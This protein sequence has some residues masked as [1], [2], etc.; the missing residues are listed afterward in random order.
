MTQAT[1]TADDSSRVTLGSR[2]GFILLVGLVGGVLGALVWRGA[3]YFLQLQSVHFI[4][5]AWI[6]YI[7]VLFAG[8]VVR[9]PGAIAISGALTAVVASIV[10]SVASLLL[11]GVG[12]N[13][14]P[15]HLLASIG[16]FLVQLV[17][18]VVVGELIGVALWSRPAVAGR[19]WGISVAVVVA[20]LATSA[21]AALREILSDPVPVLLQSVV[22]PVLAVLGAVLAAAPV[23]D[24]LRQ[25]DVL[26]SART[27]VGVTGSA[28]GHTPTVGIPGT[29]DEHPNA[30]TSLVLGILG[31]V[32]FAPL[33]PVAL[34]MAVRGRREAALQPGR[35]RTS[36][37]LQAGYV[38][39][40][41]GTVALALAVVVVVVGLASLALRPH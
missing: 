18:V 14:D 29:G 40:I 39:G 35:Y 32:L 37:S 25:R 5:A 23:R 33:A 6:G 27:R 20:I 15:S 31:L 24:R 34:S 9:R 13:L 7:H 28:D 11:P 3:S 8:L 4:A 1:Q 22:G 2:I 16:P 41:I 17:V 26:K 36:G 19:D 12:R 10:Y 21:Q 38:L 30:T